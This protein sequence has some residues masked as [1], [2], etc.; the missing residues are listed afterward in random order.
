M[1]GDGEREA[2]SWVQLGF[3]HGKGDKRKSRKS[4]RNQKE[5]KRGGGREEE[6]RMRR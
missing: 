5:G 2:N 1:T 6:E 3:G 4:V